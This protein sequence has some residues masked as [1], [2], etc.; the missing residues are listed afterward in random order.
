MKITRNFKKIAE[1]EIVP[2]L[3]FSENYGVAVY[4][5][6]HQIQHEKDVLYYKS[7]LGKCFKKI[8]EARK[9]YTLNRY[10]ERVEPKEHSESYQ[11]FLSF[12]W[13]LNLNDLKEIAEFY[14]Q[15]Q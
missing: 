8:Y 3:Y 10:L 5:C 1:Y 4:F 14:N 11:Q 2:N 12:M 15:A 7:W 9:N 6:L 13:N